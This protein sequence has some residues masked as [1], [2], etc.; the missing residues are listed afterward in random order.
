MPSGYVGPYPPLKSKVLRGPGLALRVRVW[1]NAKKLDSALA[2]GADP[3]ESRKLALRAEQLADP[4][5][6][7]RYADAIDDV[8]ALAEGGAYPQFVPTR[9][10][11]RRAYINANRQL[12][13]ELSRRLRGQGPHPVRGVAMA[14][15]LIEDGGGPLYLNQRAET[16]ERNL[17]ATLYAL[18]PPTEYRA[19]VAA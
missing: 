14:A 11:F 16:L 6:R 19:R 18:D 17:Q 12:L 15:V 10:P 2:R 13:K 7:R 9:V 1:L 5:T 3:T 8:L 4:Y